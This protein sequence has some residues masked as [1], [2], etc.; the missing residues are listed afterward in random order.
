MSCS[1]RWTYDVN[2]YFSPAFGPLFEHVCS[3]SGVLNFY[4]SYPTN[5]SVK[6]SGLYHGRNKANKI[7]F[8]EGIFISSVHNIIRSEFFVMPCLAWNTVSELLYDMFEAGTNAGM[9]HETSRHILHW[10]HMFIG[11]YVFANCMCRGKRSW[12]L[13]VI[14][15]DRGSIIS[16][17]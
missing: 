12:L 5:Q 10:Y 2:Y 8:W 14:H 6:E 16:A 9:K 11:I 3:I 15:S 1:P 17:N 7:C 4:I 13:E